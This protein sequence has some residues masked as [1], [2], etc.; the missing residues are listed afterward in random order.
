MIAK[1]LVSSSSKETGA[2]LREY[3][4]NRGV[5]FPIGAPNLIC[6]GASGHARRVLNQ[7]CDTDKIERMYRMRDERVRTVP[8]F[9]K[10][11]L[12]SN[13]NS[14]FPLLARRAYGFGGTD[15]VPV[16][17]PEELPWR[18]AAGWDW[19]SRY[20]PV[21]TE[22]RVWVFQGKH[23]DTYEKV[24]CR[25]E[26]YKYIGRN[27]RNGFEFRPVTPN[28]TLLTNLAN[29][30]VRAI[31]LDFAAVDMLEGLDHEVYVLEV[32]TAPG[33]IASHAEP[34]LGKLADEMVGWLE[35]E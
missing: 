30:A 3:L 4:S 26:E 2:L 9:T 21:K 20:I 5:R 10:N 34:T 15:I 27:F 17:Q 31:G 25:P 24:M 28:P 19:F 13:F 22:Y 12:P 7:A 32:N 23:L 35:K 6:Y 29:Q 8:W 1:L 33:V 18:I 11:D 16:F 14:Y